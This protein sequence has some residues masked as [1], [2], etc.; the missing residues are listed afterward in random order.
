MSSFMTIQYNSDSDSADDFDF[1]PVSGGGS[2]VSGSDSENNRD[3]ESDDGRYELM[4]DVAR[5]DRDTMD[6]TVANVSKAKRP[7]EPP[8]TVTVDD[9]PLA[10]SRLET[11]AINSAEESRSIPVLK[12]PAVA[13]IADTGGIAA[14][15]A[16][17]IESTE[18]NAT[19]PSKPQ[20]KKKKVMATAE[21]KQAVASTL[22]E[23]GVSSGLNDVVVVPVEV[24]KKKK[25]PKPGTKYKKRTPASEKGLEKTK[26]GA[27]ASRQ[28][29]TSKR[30][31]LSKKA[32]AAAE[33]AASTTMAPTSLRSKFYSTQID[34]DHPLESFKWPYSPFTPDFKSQHSLRNNMVLNLSTSVQEMQRSNNIASDHLQQLDYQLQSSR[35]NLKTSLDEIQFRKG[36]LRDMS[37]MAVDIVRKLSAARSSRSAVGEPRPETI[38]SCPSS[39]NISSSASSLGSIG[40]ASGFRE[41]GHALLSDHASTDEM[42]LVGVISSESQDP[43]RQEVL[44]QQQGLQRQHQRQQRQQQ[45]QHQQQQQQ[46]QQQQPGQPEILRGLNDSNIRTFLEKIREVE[47]AQRWPSSLA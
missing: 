30:G 39:I 38:P 19:Q 12:P 26:K 31:K 6:P 20:S 11:T 41:G 40:S 34:A 17:T 10:H 44:R 2:S 21:T 47:H 29:T 24:V 8:S 7:L 43:A 23:S 37:I 46:Q 5:E 13:G 45:Q 35:Q 33:V 22:A 16:E 1:E 18:A 9:D 36:Q 42:D 27:A 25:G 32:Q 28:D 3:N 14:D 4:S 15:D